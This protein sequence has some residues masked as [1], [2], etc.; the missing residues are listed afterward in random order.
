M[1]EKGPDGRSLK[2]AIDQKLSEVATEIFWLLQEHSQTELEELRRLLMERITA[3]VELI[4]TAF[5]SDRGSQGPGCVRV[6]R[7]E[8]CGGQCAD[9]L[10]T[11]LHISHL[12]Y[13]QPISIQ[14]RFPL[15]RCSLDISIGSGRLS[16]T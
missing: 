13:P 12:I 14:Q 3:A 5:G 7:G 9:P 16:R 4:L 15:R 10:T 2:A 8:E 11:L 6:D 1:S